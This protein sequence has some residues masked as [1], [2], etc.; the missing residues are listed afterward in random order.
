[1][2]VGLGEK[3]KVIFK[4]PTFFMSALLFVDKDFG[5]NIG[6][7]LCAFPFCQALQTYFVFIHFFMI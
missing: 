5:G 4:P 7:Q 1:M 6:L 3:E 2:T